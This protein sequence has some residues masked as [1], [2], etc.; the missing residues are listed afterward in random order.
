MTINYKLY[1]KY[2]LKD[3][4]LF[5]T[6]TKYILKNNFFYEEGVPVIKSFENHLHLIVLKE[7]TLFVDL[8][9]LK[10]FTNFLGEF[11]FE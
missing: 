7:K 2:Y 9:E 10:C 5:L 4:E 11:N 3:Y 6:K 1:R 8:K